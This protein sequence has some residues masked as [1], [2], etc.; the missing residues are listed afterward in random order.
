M[1]NNGQLFPMLRKLSIGLKRSSLG[2]LE[3]RYRELSV[4]P[5]T[6][7]SSQVAPGRSGLFVDGA[8]L[9]STLRDDR[10]S[11]GASVNSCVISARYKK[12]DAGGNGVGVESEAFARVSPALGDS[13]V[14][15]PLCVDSAGVSRAP[16][17]SPVVRLLCADSGGV[18]RAPGDS[19]VV[20]PLCVDSA[21]RLVLLEWMD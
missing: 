15:R 20:Q 6:P 12:H 19:L 9:E 17:D 11:S 2:T 5:L 10:S 14:V 21:A 1:S 3:M 16:G 13:S 4:D 18:S 8:R 7:S